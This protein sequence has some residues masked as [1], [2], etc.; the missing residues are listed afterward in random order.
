[1]LTLQSIL[2][3]RNTYI[4]IVYDF[5]FYFQFTDDDNQPIYFVISLFNACEKQ[6]FSLKNDSD[7][8]VHSALAK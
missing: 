3:S 8:S 1:M 5:M 7:F 6:E 4:L 2:S